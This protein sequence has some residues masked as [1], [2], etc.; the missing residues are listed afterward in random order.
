MNHYLSRHLVTPLL[1]IATAV[2][3]S[4]PAAQ[5]C[6]QQSRCCQA[7]RCCCCAP[8]SPSASSAESDKAACCQRKVVER[9]CSCSVQQQLPANVTAV[10]SVDLR[11][12]IGWG[13][14]AA[15][16]APLDALLNKWGAKAETRTFLIFAPRLQILFCFWQI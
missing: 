7:N 5:G 13:S 16:S 4:L 3:G 8:T 9:R 6:G 15:G 1:V 10:Q 14:S 2:T 12:Q 11:T